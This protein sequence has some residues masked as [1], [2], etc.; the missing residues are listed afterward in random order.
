M[1]TNCGHILI[2]FQEIS[3]EDY[4]RV[5][6][7]DNSRKFYEE[8]LTVYNISTSISDDNL[9][10]IFNCG[11]LYERLVND[12]KFKKFKN[13][14]F[15][16]VHAGLWLL[17]KHDENNLKWYK[18]SFINWTRQRVSTYIDDMDEESLS[19]SIKDEL[20]NFKW[21]FSTPEYIQIKIDDDKLDYI[22]LNYESTKNSKYMVSVKH[23][24]TLIALYANMNYGKITSKTTPNN[25]VSLNKN[26]D[27]P[28]H[29]PRPVDNIVESENVIDIEK[30]EDDVEKKEGDVVE[31]IIEEADTNRGIVLNKSILTPQEVEYILT[32]L[33]VDNETLCRFA[34]SFEFSKLQ[35]NILD[36]QSVYI[37]EESS[38]FGLS[39]APLDGFEINRSIG[40][41]DFFTNDVI[42]DKRLRDKFCSETTCNKNEIPKKNI[43]I[44]TNILNNMVHTFHNDLTII[45]LHEFEKLSTFAYNSSITENVLNN[46]NKNI[47]TKQFVEE[48]SEL[49]KILN[50]NDL[51]EEDPTKDKTGG[52]KN[53]QDSKM[54]LQHIFTKMYVDQYKNDNVET[55]ASTV[56]DNVYKHLK[57]SSR[58]HEN[59]INKNK[60]GQ[61]LVNLGVKKVRKA[62]G[63]FYG[64]ED[65]N[66][67]ESNLMDVVCKPV[68]DT[69]IPS[70]EPGLVIDFSKVD[71][72]N[73]QLRPLPR[74]T[75][76][77]YS[78]FSTLKP[79]SFIKVENR[80]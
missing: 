44:Y 40:D 32:Y 27:T 22:I 23:I 75:N 19:E 56:I 51:A 10:I 33:N 73:Y 15:K 37:P 80:E 26:V 55:I 20:W 8:L 64:M 21:D 14:Q 52:E 38:I 76:I 5:I 25:I 72:T 53:N 79:G 46:I 62:K 35:K 31:L 61:D 68:L 65:S 57:N 7:V 43:S 50:T 69:Q 16:H 41:L 78:L 39:Y 77:D 36:A 17:G 6:T 47:I 34:M 63:Y 67:K 18:D 70:P 29:T 24:L 59:L 42:V 11:D 2:F 48:L 71:K 49:I 12:L 54:D 58:L 74:T 45:T 1:H 9:N 3:G 66:E 30:T 28:T 13:Q 60:I 4:I